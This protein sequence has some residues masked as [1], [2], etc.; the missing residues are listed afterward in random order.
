MGNQYQRPKLYK[1]VQKKILKGHIPPKMPYVTLG[2]PSGKY[3]K[4]GKIKHA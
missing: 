3:L 1:K 4:I 2:N